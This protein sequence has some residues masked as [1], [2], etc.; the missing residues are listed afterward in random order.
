MR[1]HCQDNNGHQYVLQRRPR[2]AVGMRS[3]RAI[4][5]APSGNPA[6]DKPVN[7]TQI[8]Y[9]QGRG[10]RLRP[11]PGEPMPGRRVRQCHFCPPLP[12]RSVPGIGS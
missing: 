7:G 8:Q 4:T 5:A 10:H 2:I 6:A 3:G 9:E 12:S 1:E 11:P